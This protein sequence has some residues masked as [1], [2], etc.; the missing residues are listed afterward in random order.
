MKRTEIAA[1]LAEPAAY[2]EQK[3]AVCGWVRTLRSSGKV[4]FIALH[5]GSS[6]GTLQVLL[7]RDEFAGFDDAVKLNVGAAI[8]VA[9][10]LSLTPNAS[11]PCELRAAEI[12]VEGGS[13]AEY[14]LQKKRHT[15]EFLRTMPH[16]R[17]RT[18]TLQAV[19]RVRAAAAQAIHSFFREQGFFYVH[20]PI[21]STGDAEGAGEQFRISAGEGSAEFFGQPAYLTV[22]GQ[23][24][25]EALAMS[26]GKIYTFGPTFRAEDS[27]TARHAAEF[28]MIE[29]EM[30]FADL[31]DDMELA[32]AMLKSVI[33]SVLRDCPAE[34]AFLRQYYDKELLARLEHVCSAP[35]ARV[36][37]TAA[38][39]LLEPHNAKFAYPIAWGQDLQTEHERFLTEEIYCAPVFVTDYPEG[40]KAFYMRR[41]DDGK[42][43]AAV[44][45]LVPGVGEIIGGSQR[46]ER[47]PLLEERMRARGMDPQDY[48]RYLDLRRWGGCRHCGFGLGFERLVMYLTGIANIRDVLPY[49]RTAG[50][51]V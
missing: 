9:G 44:D 22:S 19:F 37:Y 13:D 20:T 26:L 14:P 1:I 12:T 35:F 38:V 2:A 39:A 18:N 33:A 3:L 10:T 51:A 8:C 50:S 25:G 34:L 4:A 23:L 30:A 36:T 47:L 24:E 43:V 6:F 42:T 7:A 32:E 16:L 17:G 48:A 45:C 29:P 31:D 40:I 15:P 49:P 28:W 41:N 46:E 27:H 21:I 5:D 11:Q